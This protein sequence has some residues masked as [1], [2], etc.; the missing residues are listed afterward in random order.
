MMFSDSAIVIVTVQVLRR[1]GGGKFWYRVAFT[2]KTARSLVRWFSGK[3][4]KLLPP[5]VRF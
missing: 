4:L 3:S 1:P 2:V 5:D